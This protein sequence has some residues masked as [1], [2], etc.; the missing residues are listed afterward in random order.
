MSLA[1]SSAN[2]TV[3]EAVRPS[4]ELGSFGGSAMKM[5]HAVWILCLPSMGVVVSAC[6][7][8]SP[9][10]VKMEPQDQTEKDDDT[11]GGAKKGGGAGGGGGAAAAACAGK[12]T[13]PDLGKLTA[14]GGGKGHCY[15]KAKTP[16]PESFTACPNPA[17]VCVPDE[18]LQAGGSPLKSCKSIVGPGGCIN[19]MLLAVPDA[20]KESAKA[21]TKDVCSEGLVCAPCTDPRSGGATPFCQPIGVFAEACTVSAGGADGGA[22]APAA[23]AS[24]TCCTTKGKSNGVCITDAVM[25]ADQKADAPQ[26]TCTGAT[27]CVPAAFVQGKPVTCAAGLLGTGVCM[28]KCFNAMMSLAGSIGILRSDGCGDTEVCVPCALVKG[29]GVPTCD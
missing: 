23:A 5:R 20:E 3:L 17:E 24:Q 26:D 29:K 19:L 21:L 1:I 13:K 28:D 10:N 12:V 11:D 16:A 4:Q 18:I 7:L 25:S 9:T 27:K 14:C 6:T 8:A 22:G 15:D 2:E